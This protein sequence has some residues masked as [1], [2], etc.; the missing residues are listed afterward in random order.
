[1]SSNSDASI[2][3]ELYSLVLQFLKDAGLSQTAKIFKKEVNKSTKDVNQKYG[4]VEMFK[5]YNSLVA[6]KNIEKVGSDDSPSSDSSNNVENESNDESSSGDDDQS[7]ENEVLMKGVNLKNGSGEPS[8]EEL[9]NDIEAEDSSSS[10]SEDDDDSSDSSDSSSIEVENNVNALSPGKESESSDSDSSDSSSEQ[11]ENEEQSVATSHVSKDSDP[12]SESSSES[13]SDNNLSE[14]EENGEMEILS[15]NESSSEESDKEQE[16]S[17]NVADNNK[18]NGNNSSNDESEE[19]DS[20][21]ENESKSGNTNNN[22]NNIKEHNGENRDKLFRSNGK[23]ASTEIDKSESS[24]EKNS[25]YKINVTPLTNGNKLKHKLDS[26]DDTLDYTGPSKKINSSTSTT[27][28]TTSVHFKPLS[29]YKNQKKNSKSNK[30]E[31]KSNGDGN[32]YNR[33]INLEKVE[34]LDERLKDNSFLAKD[35]AVDSYGYKAH[36]DLINTRG[37]DFR[38]QKTKKKRGSYRGGKIDFESHSIKFAV[39]D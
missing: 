9:K 4:L 14:G 25:S 34:F 37:K 35:G 6:S 19:S 5:S 11:S 13:S 33:R 18:T 28:V 31:N 36:N 1:M 32:I 12:S 30:M 3:T 29:V 38:A 22:I 27:Y 15:D 10:S 16:E 23:I 26:D 8:D 21:S 7:S 39:D 2:P 17:S 24:N 20:E